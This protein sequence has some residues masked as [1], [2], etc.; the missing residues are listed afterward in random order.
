MV[1]SIPNAG[2]VLVN[3]RGLICSIDQSIAKLLHIETSDAL[4]RR[5]TEILPDTRLLEVLV[6]LQ[7]LRHEQVINRV[8]VKVSYHPVSYSEIFTGVFITIEPLKSSAL[9][10][11]ENRQVLVDLYEG[12]LSDLPLGLAVVNRQGRAVFMNED[13][14]QIL[15]YSSQELIGLS[16]QKNVPFSRISEILQTGKPRLLI[17]LEYQGK[18]FLL[19]E[20]PIVSQGQTIGGIS[21]ILSRERIEGQDVRNL[22]ERIQ[23]LENKLLFYKEELLELR[24]QRSPLE[25][26][27]GESPEMHK[28][29]HV[30]QRV[31][32]HD[33]NVLITGESGTGKGLLAQT[34][35]QLSPRKGEPFIKINC[36]AIP[37]NLLESE[38]FGYEE[39]AF[40]GALKGGKPG[41]FE[42]AQGGTIF[43]DEI[44][45]MPLTM[46]AK[47]LRVLQEKSF[48]RIGGNKT[49]TVDVR[50]IAATHRDLVKL[51]DQGEFRLDLYYRLAVI[52]LDLPPLRQRPMDICRLTEEITQKLSAKYGKPI[53]GLTPTVEKILRTYPWPGNVRELENVLEYAFNFLELGENVIDLLHLP[54]N[55]VNSS[56]QN[57]TE[58]EQKSRDPKQQ[59]PESICISLEDAVAQ[60]ESEAIVRALKLTQGNKQA[61]ARVLGIHVSGLYQKLKK[62]S[63]LMD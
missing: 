58:H 41:K 32:L 2:C 24:S 7:P 26:I 56:P 17:D 63:N 34:I 5:L 19:S 57:G 18:V 53:K 45:D 23:I 3:E 27:Q 4:G 42:L 35:H 6:S 29:K 1:A 49:L 44:G 47:I 39:G 13:Y 8:K 12:I 16:L 21:K 31:A 20:I 59:N 54:A 40:T 28:L 10:E 43:L 30:A 55:V 51:I 9:D 48:E 61:A 22:M 50:V 37:E 11:R 25:E 52:S 36:A 33:A 38:L 14:S 15:G 46:Q 60:A 62:Y